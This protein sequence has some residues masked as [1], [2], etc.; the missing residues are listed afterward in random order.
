LNKKVTIK[1]IA[2][3][4]GVGIS[5]VSRALNGYAIMKEDTRERILQISRE[6]N[7]VPNAAARMLVTRG[8]ATTTIAL[9]IPVVAHQFFFEIISN[10]Q[11]YLKTQDIHLMV[12]NTDRGHESVIHHIIGMHMAGVL[13]L[14]DPPLLPSE[15]RL[16]E[17]H[18]IPLLYVDRHDDNCN[19]ITFDNTYGGQLAAQYFIKKECKKVLMMGIT[20][21]TTQQ[22]ERFSGFRVEI[23]KHSP[24]IQVNELCINQERES[25]EISKTVLNDKSLDGIFYFTDFMGFGGIQAKLETSSKVLLVGY[26][27]IFPSKF[28]KLTTVRQSTKVLGHEAAKGMASMVIDPNFANIK[29]GFQK[30]LDPELVIRQN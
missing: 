3:K 16:L 12:F 27:D 26:D 1:D 9:L 21:R 29:N 18:R 10:I 4:A 14:G 15:E 17:L 7:Y 13:V 11:S 2:E 20:D 8:T 30:I 22:T 24:H 25:Y 23:A 5:T 19:Y 28:M 6:M